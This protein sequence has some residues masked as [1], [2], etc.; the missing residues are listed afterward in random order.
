MR[1]NIRGV[2]PGDRDEIIR[3]SSRIWEGEDYIPFVFDEW[4]RD[5]NSFFACAEIDGHI[6]GFGRYVRIANGYAW[7]E[8]LRVDP[9]YQGYGIGKALTNFFI[10]LG[11]KECVKSLALSTYIDNR[12]SIHIIEKKGFVKVAEFVYCKAE[13][14]YRLFEKEQ[15]HL[16]ENIDACIL[17][18]FI[19]NSSFV[20]SS[21]SYFPYGWRFINTKFD[22]KPI[23]EKTN[24]A[25]GYSKNREITGVACGGEVIKN[26]G[27][28]D[29][30]FI[31]GT[32]EA[33]L[34][35]AKG[36]L[37]FLEKY[38]TIEFMIP[39]LDGQPIEAINVLKQLKVENYNN[40]APDVFVYEKSLLT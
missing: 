16:I 32:E 38:H 21:G 3:I 15:I 6:A 4:A 7:L 10:D 13:R 8:G 23:L 5:D 14:N 35:L 20:T 34:N 36:V 24:F 18:T 2:L 37:N 33:V 22:L 17:H 19:K 12:A 30:F 11:M 29:I 9:V 28:L 1:V 31:D 25:L 40:Y 27:I 26:S 39:V